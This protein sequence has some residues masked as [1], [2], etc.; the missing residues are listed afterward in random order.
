[1][2]Q[3]K[4]K[5]VGVGLLS[6]VTGTLVVL[7]T[8]L[9]INHFSEGLQNEK[10][11][12]ISSVQFERKPPPEQQVKPK[13]KPKPKPKRTPRTAPEP[14]TGLDTALSGIDMG[15]PGF[16]SEDLN[17][18]GGDLMGGEDGVVMT[19]DTVDQPPQAVYQAPMQYPARAKVKG[20]EGYVVL[21]L[22]I[23]VTGEIEQIELVESQPQGVFDQVATQG[24]SS[25]QFEPAMYQGQAVRSWAKQRVR[26]DLTGA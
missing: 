9:L 20:V 18:L 10:A 14:L 3:E 25:W 8:V 7:G 23:G 2:N 26:F 16:S 6:M 5:R 21:S 24:V 4:F 12:A 22:L 17:D 13:P 19:D 11:E 1:M 15:L